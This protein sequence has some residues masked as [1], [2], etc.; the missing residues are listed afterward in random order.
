MC[1]FHHLIDGASPRHH[2]LLVQ[3]FTKKHES[4]L[5]A[6]NFHDDKQSPGEFCSR[7]GDW[8]AA[9]FVPCDVIIIL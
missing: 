6:F 3:N 9:C 8:A 7:I 2:H 1:P 5:D 4:N